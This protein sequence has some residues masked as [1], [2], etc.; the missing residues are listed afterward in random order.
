MILKNS[1]DFPDAFL[2]RM[3]AW[4][5]KQVQLPV[6][7]LRRATF[8]NVKR[9]HAFSGLGGGRGIIVRIGGADRYPVAAFPRHGTTHPALA[10]RLEGLI[11][12]TAHECYHCRQS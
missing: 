6:R 11:S 7:W 2:R 3:T 8:R 4:C 12:T 5:C 9:G 10:D 1:T